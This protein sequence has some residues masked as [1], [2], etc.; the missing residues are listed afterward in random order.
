[1]AKDSGAWRPILNLKA[2]N[3]YVLPSHF[4]ME[5][6]RTVTDCIGEAAQQRR[7]TSEHLR[8]SETSETWAVSIDLKDAYFHVPV[9]PEH[10]KYLRYADGRAYKFQVLS[11]GLSMAL[12]V[13]TRVVR[14]IEAFLKVHGVDMHQYLDDWLLK[15]QSKTHIKRQRVL[16]LFW[17]N[18]LGFLV[19][20]R[21]S[22][23]VPTQQPAF[24]GSRLDLLRMVVFP[25]ERRVEILSRLA[26]AL[27]TWG[28]Q[29]ANTWQK[30]LGHLSSLKDLVPMAV[31]HTRPVRL[32]FH[33]QWP[34]ATDNPFIQIYPSQETEDELRWWAS[35]A[36]LTAGRPFLRHILKKKLLLI[37][38]SVCLCH[39]ANSRHF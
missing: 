22:Q 30:F 29:P 27:L 1:M 2:F 20:E 6:L 23:L 3:A 8:D 4:H 24:L 34:Q 16:P 11:F 37:S 33:E 39:G 5:T 28:P 7:N 19:N 36:N 35:Q 10:T 25:S 12:R 21:K 14:V 15:K 13:F 26:A 31:T 9:L 18:K 38:W 17:V 32:M